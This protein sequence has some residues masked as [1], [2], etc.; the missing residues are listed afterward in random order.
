MGKKQ[1][2]RYLKGAKVGWGR[3]TRLVFGFV[4]ITLC[5]LPQGGGGPR[6]ERVLGSSSPAAVPR[7][8]IPPPYPRP[9]VAAGAI[10]LCRRG[11]TARK[12]RHGALRWADYCG[13]SWRA[14]GK[15]KKNMEKGRSGRDH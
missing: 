11:K 10:A 9:S 5:G 15:R 1:L 6:I 3:P 2:G 8:C 7:R 13:R 14:V 12:L 4:I